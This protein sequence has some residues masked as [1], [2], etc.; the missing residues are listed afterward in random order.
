MSL[1]LTVLAFLSVSVKRSFHALKI[2]QEITMTA[3]EK[4]QLNCSFAGC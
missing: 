3:A 1:S 4:A 2:G